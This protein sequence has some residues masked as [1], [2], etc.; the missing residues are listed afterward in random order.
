MTGQQWLIPGDTESG[1]AHSPQ[2]LCHGW[3][4]ISSHSGDNKNHGV[5]LQSCLT[6]VATSL[7]PDIQLSAL[8]TINYL[9]CHGLHPRSFPLS[10]FQMHLLAHPVPKEA[11]DSQWWRRGHTWAGNPFQ[12]QHQEHTELHF[13]ESQFLLMPL[14]KIL[15]YLL[16]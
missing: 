2:R 14:Y 7:F 3:A 9:Y 5:L 10:I 12:T 6:V 13:S 4:H 15:I 11:H 16:R 1:L 8:M